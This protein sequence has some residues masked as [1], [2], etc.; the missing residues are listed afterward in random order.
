M[1]YLIIQN[2]GEIIPQDIILMGSS[3]KRGK[4]D[5]IG[6]F[7]SG[8][9]YALA[10]LLRNNCNVVIFAGKKEIPIEKRMT[11]HR[12]IP[13]DVIYV[14]GE[15]TN[16]TTEL[17]LKWTAW[18]AL[19]ELISNAIDESDEVV[20]QIFTNDIARFTKE[21]ITSIFIPIIDSIKDVMDN[22]E[23]YFAFE[24]KPDWIGEKG[25]LYLRSEEGDVNI[26]RKGI[27]CHDTSCQSLVDYNF[28]HIPI[29][30]DRLIEGG[31]S[32]FDECAA[33]LLE[34]VDDVNIIKQVILSDY[35][36]TFPKEVNGIWLEAYRQLVADGYKFTTKTMKNI[37]GIT[38][39]GLV[40]SGEHLKALI[41]AG[42]I[43]NPLEA[44]FQHLDFVF[45]RVDGP[46]EEVERLLS[47]FG[48]FK[49]YFGKMDS[50][51]DVKIKDNEMYVKHTYATKAP[52]Y[53]AAKCLMEHPKGIELI[54]GLL[55]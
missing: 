2:K 16:I 30:E 15:N 23:H 29:T 27:R 20:E 31:I 45:N 34:D 53:T 17:G 49:V 21:G 1:K 40:I 41:S 32:K 52:E 46:S 37:L 3:T 9:K 51:K 12:G 18:M 11:E 25:M 43:S 35:K 38:T 19:R 6:Q 10:W 28:N 7:G 13:R 42:F 44:I 26:Y 48:E 47:R 8:S 39:D 50:Y 54:G 55:K 4:N 36:D 14:N 22:Y 5:K 24:R 33:E